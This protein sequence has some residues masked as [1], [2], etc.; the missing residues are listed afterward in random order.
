M[1]V[2]LLYTYLQI[3]TWN[4][5]NLLIDEFVNKIKKKYGKLLSIYVLDS[6]IVRFAKICPI[7][8]H[9]YSKKLP[10]YDNIH[11]FSSYEELLNFFYTS[12]QFDEIDTT[13]LYVMLFKDITNYQYLINLHFIRQS[14]RTKKRFR[15]IYFNDMKKEI[16]NDIKYRHLIQC[17]YNGSINEDFL[18][19][20]C[21]HCVSPD[22]E[23]SHFEYISINQFFYL[24]IIVTKDETVGCID[25]SNKLIIRKNHTNNCV[26][27]SLFYRSLACIVRDNK[28]DS[29]IE[30]YGYDFIPYNDI[31]HSCVN[32]D[33][34]MISINSKLKDNLKL[35]SKEI[36]INNDTN[37]NIFI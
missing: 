2:H 26:C 22:I 35:F 25:E 32:N 27:L 36:K 19:K 24:I 34:S 17:K 30:P 1:L 10:N 8:C 29:Y 14:I 37:V 16:D 18:Y 23:I 12:I 31:L 28:I 21:K 33:Y 7:V 4:D 15:I 5:L 9:I 13:N 3:Q 11:S 20:L 6:D